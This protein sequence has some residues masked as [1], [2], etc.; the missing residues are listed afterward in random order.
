MTRQHARAKN[1]SSNWWLVARLWGRRWNFCSAFIFTFHFRAA[2]PR[3]AVC[4]DVC[5]C[6]VCVMANKKVNKKKGRR[7][8]LCCRPMPSLPRHDIRSAFV[9][10]NFNLI[11]TQPSELRLSYNDVWYENL[12]RT[13]FVSSNETAWQR[14]VNMSSRLQRK[15]NLRWVRARRRQR[16]LTSTSSSHLMWWKRELKRSVDCCGIEIMCCVLWE[17]RNC[18]ARPS[19]EMWE[20]FTDLRISP[21]RF[22]WLH[23]DHLLFIFIFFSCSKT[24][25]LYCTEGEDFRSIMNLMSEKSKP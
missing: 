9:V 5:R 16:A 4:A 6:F 1:Q 24:W 10:Y 11:K 19:D 17:T 14:C 22:L 18:C 7:E 13:T 21:M 8:V 2:R 3:C 20:R 25:N 12:S 23:L 15:S